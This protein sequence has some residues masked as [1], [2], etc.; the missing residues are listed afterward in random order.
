MLRIMRI[1]GDDVR[2]SSREELPARSQRRF[3]KPPEHGLC[4]QLYRAAVAYPAFEFSD[5][6]TQQGV[7]LGMRDYRPQPARKQKRQNIGSISRYLLIGELHQ[8]VRPMRERVLFRRSA[9]ILDPLRSDMEFAAVVDPHS[10][11]R[12][13]LQLVN[14]CFD[15]RR[16]ES[17]LQVSMR[18]GNDLR[19]ARS[20]GDAQHFD[21][22]LHGCRS[23]IE[24]RQDMAVYIDHRPA[25]T[26]GRIARGLYGR[27][28]LS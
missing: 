2:E 27:V 5:P 23:V 20:H 18:C 19:G 10:T 11:S 13:L 12:V 1:G 8:Q 4:G 14:G 3:A 28:A 21:R 9:G 24:A 15:C 6:S 25:K 16:I 17:I 22:L 26:I 7:S